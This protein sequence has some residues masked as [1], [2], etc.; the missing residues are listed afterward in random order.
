MKLDEY[1]KGLE[2]EPFQAAL[3]HYMEVDDVND[4][5][6]QKGGEWFTMPNRWG[7]VH[8]DGNYLFFITDDDGIG[9]IWHTEER[10]DEDSLVEYIKD[11]FD[12]KLAAARA[13]AERDQM[14]QFLQCTYGYPPKQAERTA[15]RFSKYEDIFEEF[16][17]FQHCHVMAQ[18][19][20]NRV[21]E[22][23]YTAQQLVKTCQLTE[24]D[25]YLLLIRLREEPEA[26]LKELKAKGM[27]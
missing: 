15:A 3:P 12:I 14:C 10:E 26:A 19:Q 7:V 24:P 11:R 5:G 6:L 1:R 16:R 13:R 9:R 2:N 25:A 21:T 27:E 8:K 17:N 4:W 22:Q 20:G 23:G 18:K